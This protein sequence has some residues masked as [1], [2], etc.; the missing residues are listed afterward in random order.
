MKRFIEGEDRSQ[1]T[2]FPERLDNYIGE[3]NSVRVVGVFVD[4]LDL[5]NL[6]FKQVEPLA[7]SR[8]SIHP[9]VLLKLY[10][11]GYL[12]RVQSSR[13]LEREAA[14]NV[15]VMRLTGKLRPD[16]KSIA[17][18][19]KDNGSAIRKICAQFVDLCRQLQLFINAGVAIDG[20]KFKAVNTHDK[21]CT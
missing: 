12:S 17:N 5:L 10:I 3:D 20:S 9:I 13:R 14:G 18:F 6:G 16:H 19:R 1:S 8:P 11:S 7:I 2:L 21:N 4:E 15:E